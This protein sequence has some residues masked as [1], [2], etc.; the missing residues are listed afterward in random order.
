MQ[1]PDTFNLIVAIEE[2]GGF[3]VILAIFLIAFI[4]MIKLNNKSIKNLEQTIIKDTEEY[5]TNI[6]N[7]NTKMLE[8]FFKNNG[9]L[10]KSDT[11]ENRKKN[12]KEELF[13]MFI[14]LRDSLKDKCKDTMNKVG[15]NR[16]AI[17]LFHNGMHSTH[18]INFFKM[19]CICEC[20][21]IGSGIQERTIEHSGI[22][23]N[24]FDDMIDKLIDEGQY[25]IQN[26]ESIL[27][28]NKKIFKSQ[29]SI[30]YSKLVAI[31]DSNN[32]IMGFV[33]ADFPHAQSS[34][35]DKIED[36]YMKDLACIISPILA[37]SDYTNFNINNLNQH[38]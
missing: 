27:K 6:L 8:E 28:T 5:R 37:Y 29:S 12:S 10:V 31:F 35:T 9:Q 16:L 11:K 18:G 36:E 30:K 26:D 32:N 33:L 38:D 34:K 13:V 2:Y 25:V 17:Y 23:I 14:K 19:T 20:V 21:V 15:A 24:I 22:P 3:A 1:Y 4:A 7:Q